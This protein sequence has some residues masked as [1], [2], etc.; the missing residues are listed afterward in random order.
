MPGLW[1]G[2][3]GYGERG[4][5]AVV[6]RLSMIHARVKVVCD[7]CLAEATLCDARF[8][9]TMSNLEQL[10]GSRL[11]EGWN[12]VSIPYIYGPSDPFVRH[13]SAILCP[14]HKLDFPAIRGDG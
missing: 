14:A 3:P 6:P 5:G 1:G 4:H 11:P 8:G 7:S 12:I 2:I 9:V 13:S 10:A